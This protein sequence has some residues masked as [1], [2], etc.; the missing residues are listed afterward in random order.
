MTDVV[1]TVENVVGAVPAE[2][3]TVA[4]EVVPVVEEVA[5]AV[6]AKVE[7]V[8]KVVETKVEAVVVPV[9]KTAADFAV[10]EVA[11]AAL[12]LAEAKNKA[13]EAKNALEEGL[14]SKEAEVKAEL[15]K[16]EP[17]FISNIKIVEKVVEKLV[18]SPVSTIENAAK[19]VE[20]I[21]ASFAKNHPVAMAAI[22]FAA[23]VIVAGLAV[24]MGL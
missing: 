4:K 14:A 18:T 24:W 16:L 21:E 17:V 5:K 23:G 11:K 20:I 7:E 3:V 6:E 8:A 9:V 1:Q 22:F 13:L 2:V 15:A 12:A 10:E 19:D